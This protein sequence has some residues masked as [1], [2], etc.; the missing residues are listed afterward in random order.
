[1]TYVNLLEN[2]PIECQF[3][4][5]VEEGVVVTKLVAT[6]GD[7]TIEA[8]VQSKQKAKEKYD[9]A[10]AG[11]HAAVLAQKTKKDA[12]SLLVGNLAPAQLASLEL[13][14]VLPLRIL[15]GAFELALPASLL[16]NYT[17]L[18]AAG[19][20][21]PEAAPAPQY[22]FAY[23]FEIVSRQQQVTFVG[24]PEGSETAK[25]APGSR[26]CGAPSEKVPRR[27]LRFFSKVE[28]MLYPQLNFVARE[29][30]VAVMVNLVPTFEPV[31]PQ[32]ALL[33]NDAPVEATSISGSDFCFIFLIDRSGSM[34]IDNR[35]SIAKEALRLFIQSLPAGSQF[36]IISFGS[37]FSAMS[38]KD[39]TSGVIDYN[40]QTKEHALKHIKNMGADFGG[41]DILSP[42]VSACTLDCGDRQKRI[43]LLTDG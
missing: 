15:A 39:N 36:S 3:D 10:I 1:M 27:E 20:A 35:I 9:D 34:S 6:V 16:P 40:D 26:V 8:K 25:T 21:A 12:L 41:T 38:T 33:T 24:A 37:D 22:T 4:L 14:L 5:P 2:N 13:C 11:G 32:E 29:D 17:K 7:K 42:M 43:F 31:Q 23:D 19:P 30:E 28:D 18:E